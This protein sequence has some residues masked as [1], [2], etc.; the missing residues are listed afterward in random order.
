MVEREALVFRRLWLGSVFTSLLAPVLFLAAMGVGL[1]TLIDQHAGGAGGVDYVAFI[2]PGLLA[3]SATM[4]A[5]GESMWP[6]LGGL[7][8]QRT[9]HAMVATPMGSG[10][11]YDGLIIWA[12][13]RTLISA[14]A[15]VAIATLFG[16]VI[17]PWGILAIPAAALT[18]TAFSAPL[19]A[20]SATQDSDL[21]FAL[22]MRL[23]IIPLFLF[24]GTFF[25]ISQLPAWARPIAVCSPLWHGVQLC[26]AATTG[27]ADA[28]ALLVHLA[29]IGAFIAAGAWWGRRTFAR[30]LAS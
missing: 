21:P 7:K 29:V 27:Q 11:V 12:A 2:T 4:V 22:I 8:W 19:A 16:G 6:V 9:M 13:I 15:F 23:G 25:P 24:S 1:G 18:A 17:S 30:R 5:A 26:R 3:A 10:D 14:T 28:S 20:F